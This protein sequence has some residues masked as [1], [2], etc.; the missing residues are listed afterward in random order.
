MSVPS[1]DAQLTSRRFPGAELISQLEPN[2]TKES[3]MT[4]TSPTIPTKR[5]VLVDDSLTEVVRAYDIGRRYFQAFL[6]AGE[7]NVVSSMRRADTAEARAAGLLEAVS[8]EYRTLMANYFRRQSALDAVQRAELLGPLARLKIT[9]ALTVGTVAGDLLAGGPAAE[10]AVGNGGEPVAEAGMSATPDKLRL[11][12]DWYKVEDVQDSAPWPFTAKDE[13][14]LALVAIDETGD[15]ASV[16]HNIGSLK[17]G[18]TKSYAHP[19]L[20]LYG[21]NM[22][23]GSTFPKAYSVTLYAMDRDDGGYNQ[24]LGAAADYARQQV[25]E[26]MIARGINIYTQ[27]TIPPE[28]VNWVASVVKGLFDGLVTWLAGLLHNED[29]VLGQ[30]IRSATVGSYGGVWSTTGTLE[31]EHKQ[32]VISGKGGRHRFQTYWVKTA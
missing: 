5:G 31:A 12:L 17:K 26:E 3:F 4:I 9:D 16:A 14:T 8:P 2:R 19:G 24:F 22:T 7:R 6:L 28:I 10:A 20:K 27:N 11:M 29:D 18:Q 25:K 13:V 32:R 15:V 1:T 23:E 21:F 30:T